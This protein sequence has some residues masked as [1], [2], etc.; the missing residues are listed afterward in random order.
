MGL[1]FTILSYIVVLAVGFIIGMTYMR[2]SIERELIKVLEKYDDKH[3][4]M[5]TINEQK[6]EAVEDYKAREVIKETER[7]DEI[8]RIR[9]EEEN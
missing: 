8:K 7:H 1:L 2:D 3:S 6:E 9:E 4:N 5:D